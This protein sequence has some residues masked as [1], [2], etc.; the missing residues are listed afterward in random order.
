MYCTNCGT[1]VPEGQK[2]CENCSRIYQQAANP[3]VNYNNPQEF[4]PAAQPTDSYSAVGTEPASEPTATFSNDNKYAVNTQPTPA[5]NS[6]NNQPQYAP[7]INQTFNM[8][9]PK[10]VVTTGQWILRSLINLIP[11]VGSLVYII[12]LFVWMSDKTY[13]ESSANWAKAQLIWIAISIGLVVL[14]YLFIF[15][16][17]G[18]SF[19]ELANEMYY[20]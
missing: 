6:F 5:P 11:C 1:P 10:K 8:A 15:L 19:G 9:A 20:M 18:V 17:L 3:Q 14:V 2:L 12:M 7:P 4:N 13:E 16:I